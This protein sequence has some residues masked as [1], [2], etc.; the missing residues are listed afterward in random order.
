MGAVDDLAREDDFVTDL[1][2]R[3][4]E[5]AQV[6]RVGSGAGPEIEIAGSEARQADRRK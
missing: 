1:Q 5:S 2:A 6:E 3:L 4:A